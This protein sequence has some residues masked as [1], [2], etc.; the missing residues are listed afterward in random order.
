MF[1]FFNAVDVDRNVI[2][3]FKFFKFDLTS[4]ETQCLWD[5]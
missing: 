5:F 3:I 1:L 2:L 4:S